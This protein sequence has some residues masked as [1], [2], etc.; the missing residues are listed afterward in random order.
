MKSQVGLGIDLGSTSCRAAVVF[1]NSII[2][3]PQE[4]IYRPLMD[5]ISLDTAQTSDIQQRCKSLKWILGSKRNFFTVS[6]QTP[7]RILTNV[8]R[9]K[10]TLA[11]SLV[12]RE[13]DNCI[14]S[15]PASYLEIQ[16]RSLMEIAANAGL[17][18]VNF[19]SDLVSLLIYY[20]LN[21]R[22][23]GLYL[24]IDMGYHNCQIAAIKKENNQI[25]VLKYGNST[26]PSGRVLDISIFAHCIQK[27]SYNGYG[28]FLEGI[29]S[30]PTIWL[31]SL[32]N[33]SLAKEVLRDADY[34]HI[35]F[36]QTP[37]SEYS[38][39]L[40]LA[41]NRVSLES[42]LKIPMIKHLKWID[43]FLKSLHIKPTMLKK[44]LLC[45]GTAKMDYIQHA[46]NSHY[47][48]CQ[49][50]RLMDGAIAKGASGFASKIFEQ[51]FPQEQIFNYS[52]SQKLQYHEA[53]PHT[54][55]E[56]YELDIN[57]NKHTVSNEFQIKST[58][59]SRDENQL[60]SSLARCL[61]GL[62]IERKRTFLDKVSKWTKEA[63]GTLKDQKPYEN[64]RILKAHELL[65]S[66]NIEEAIEE[67]H[68]AFLA[69]PDDHYILEDMIEIHRLAAEKRNDKDGYE[70]AIK[71]LRCGYEHDQTNLELLDLLANRHFQQA[72]SLYLDGEYQGAL[73]AI[74]SCLNANRG[75]LEALKLRDKIRDK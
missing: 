63:E 21:R 60:I 46:I 24:V 33:V 44:I 53:E 25:H 69:N 56:I 55:S 20:S 34:A 65:K 64:W 57:L 38:Q 1:E 15:V 68:V 2:H 10:L 40:L 62:E 61:N 75:H 70:D 7:K 49:L 17:K 30:D 22:E 37:S 36:Y 47:S 35:P 8:L 31:E 48:D 32:Y 4:S 50:I 27:L 73:K 54:S 28:H 9:E 58:L 42:S 11:Q 67:A 14:I 71:W 51:S 19:I 26:M 18:N 59:E 6:G 5:W 52:F 12:G 29:E 45:G 23:N 41:I 66:G 3:I 74:N 16:R 13:I 72:N 43:S 39:Q